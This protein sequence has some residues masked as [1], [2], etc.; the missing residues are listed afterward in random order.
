MKGGNFSFSFSYKILIV[1][2]ILQTTSES[3]SHLKA[4]I[5]QHKLNKY[6]YI[7]RRVLS[8]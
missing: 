5:Y 8:T 3:F 1:L 7:K 6:Y 4:D 2:L